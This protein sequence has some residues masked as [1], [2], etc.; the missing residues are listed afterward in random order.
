MHGGLGEG[1]RAE[2]A[3]QRRREDQE[4]KQRHQRGD[5]QMARHRPAVVV[6]EMAE[7]IGKHPADGDDLSAMR[8][9]LPVDCFRAARIWEGNARKWQGGAEQL[10][11]M[12]RRSNAAGARS[13]SPARRPASVPIAPAR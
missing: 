1:L 5:R 8:V 2:K 3:G 11:R 12:P 7:R 9:S 6:V 4:R 13:S 10:P